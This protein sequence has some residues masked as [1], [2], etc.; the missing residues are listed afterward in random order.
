MHATNSNPSGIPTP[1]PTAKASELFDFVAVGVE[2]EAALDDA[3]PALTV[4]VALA[5]AVEVLEAL[6]SASPTPSCLLP[7]SWVSRRRMLKE[8]RVKLE[9]QS[10]LRSHSQTPLAGQGNMF[11]AVLR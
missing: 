10:L 11:M 1:R 8:G 5:A 3:V 7:G 9:E 2:E 4:T 6:G